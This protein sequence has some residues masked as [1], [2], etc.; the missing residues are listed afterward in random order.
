MNR[1]GRPPVKDSV[2]VQE[3]GRKVL[4]HLYAGLRSLKLYPLENSA[5]QHALD[6]LHA[7]MS[8]IV[9][10]D[11]PL[12]LRVVGDFFF[13]NETRLRLDLSNYSTF[14]S[15]ARF[16]TDHGLGCGGGA[17]GDRPERMGAVPLPPPSGAER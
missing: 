5:V 2:R 17:P 10:E 8:G 6:E 7:L 12:E 11:G 9:M 1:P 4:S 3:R 13:F 16:L 14:G 15:F